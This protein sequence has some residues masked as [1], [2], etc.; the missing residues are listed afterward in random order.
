MHTIP[1]WVGWLLALGCTLTVVTG[2][3]PSA[4]PSA[5]SGAGSI[6]VG[7]SAQSI[8]VDGITRTYRV[9]RPRVLPRRASLVVMMH[10]GY[11]SATQAE[12]ML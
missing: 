10:G 8:V 5:G 2:C 9:Y 1:R 7:S 6:P 4:A 11:G 12:I 3:R